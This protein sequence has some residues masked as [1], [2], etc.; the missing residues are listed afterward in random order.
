MFLNA[1]DIAK[2]LCP[3]DIE[4]AKI[5]AG[6]I[7]LEKFNQYIEKQISFAVETTLSGKTLE[8]LV[9]KAKESGYKIELIYSYLNDFSDCI[10]RVKTR[11]LNGGHNVEEEEITRR[12]YRS[13]INFWKYKDLADKWSLFYNGEKYSPTLVAYKFHMYCDIIDKEKYNQFLKI[14][15]LSKMLENSKGNENAK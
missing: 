12:Y 5:K 9:R 1:D 13:I 15:E 2:E 8:K 10:K 7:Y 14:T 6:R 11:V 3:D 4:S